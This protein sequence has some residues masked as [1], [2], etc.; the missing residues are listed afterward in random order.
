MRTLGAKRWVIAG[1]SRGGEFGSRLVLNHPD[2][3]AGLVLIATT[4]PRSFSLRKT[5]VDVTQ[6]SG[7]RDGTTSD[8]ALAAAR[9]RLPA[10]TRRVVISGANHSQFRFYGRHLFD[11]SP[12]ISHADQIAHTVDILLAA[13]DR[14]DGT[15]R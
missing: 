15:T 9:A 2:R 8:E 1:H 7:D 10:S 12:T 13:L 3:Y 4:H 14:A 5:S 11:G 6:V